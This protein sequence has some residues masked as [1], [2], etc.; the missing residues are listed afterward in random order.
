M[1]T[2][3]TLDKGTMYGMFSQ[4][5]EIK[6]LLKPQ[7][8]TNSIKGNIYNQGYQVAERGGKTLFLSA[9]IYNLEQ[10]RLRLSLPSAS[11]AE[12]VFELIER[13]G[14]MGCRLL[15]GKYTIILTENENTTIIRDRNGE[16]KMVYFTK[17]FFTDSYHGLFQFKNFKAVPDKQGLQRF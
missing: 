14:V 2:E 12:L 11:V 15:N 1:A 8:G 17:D 16:G 6:D 10:I 7:A 13:E 5:A 9:K 3:T 4:K